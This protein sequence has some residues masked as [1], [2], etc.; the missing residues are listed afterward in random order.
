MEDLYPLS[1]MQQGILFHALLTP[2]AEAYLPQIQLTIEG[3]TDV[4]AFRAAW[5]QAIDR[6]PVLRTAFQWE[7]RDQPFQVVYRAIELPWQEADW[8]DREDPQAQLSEFLQRDRQQP[9]NL[10]AA[11][12]MRLTLIRLGET[13][14]HLIWTQHHLILDGWS[15]AIVLQEVFASARSSDSHPPRRPYRDYIACLQQQDLSAA[16]PFGKRA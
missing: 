3:L 15:A 5:Q 1:P 6:H 7:Q 12:L 2:E 4:P 9:F 10:K 14:Y 13:R 11:P 16:K 8:R